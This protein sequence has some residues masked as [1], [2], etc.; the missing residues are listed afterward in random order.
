MYQL[1]TP[2]GIFIKYFFHEIQCPL[3]GLPWGNLFIEGTPLNRY[4][5]VR[6]NGTLFQ[7]KHKFNS[8][9]CHQ[10]RS[11]SIVKNILNR[12]RDNAR[13]KGCLLFKEEC[14]VNNLE[15]HYVTHDYANCIQVLV[16]MGMQWP[17]RSYSSFVM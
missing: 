10:L 1:I 2:W 6:G 5:Q 8:T 11:L 7:K 16:L 9:T 3:L 14:R 13:I 12:D 4:K 17:L 15:K